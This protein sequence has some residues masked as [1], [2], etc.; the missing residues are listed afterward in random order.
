MK[1]TAAVRCLQSVCMCLY[2]CSITAIESPKNYRTGESRSELSA[3]HM[4]DA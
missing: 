1:Q 2:A 4:A 3:L